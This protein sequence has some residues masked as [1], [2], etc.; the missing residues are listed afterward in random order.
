MFENEINEHSLFPR[1]LTGKI[2]HSHNFTSPKG[3]IVDIK[4]INKW[5]SGDNSNFHKIFHDSN[6]KIIQIK[7]S[8]KNL[9][10]NLRKG[11]FKNKSEFYLVN[12]IKTKHKRFFRSFKQVLKSF[13]PSKSI[14]QSIIENV[15]DKEECS[16]YINDK[17][18]N[19]NSPHFSVDS[20]A[21]TSNTKS[22]KNTLKNL[23]SRKFN[24]ASNKMHQINNNIVNSYV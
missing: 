22:N 7:K 24:Q 9:I 2:F 3:S 19:K 10:E 11:K 18:I 5:I 13:I 20:S 14:N 1:Q 6:Y 16:K 17:Y 12:N 23:I 15:K 8:I 4:T 21:V